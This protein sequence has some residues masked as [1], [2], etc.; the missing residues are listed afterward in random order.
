VNEPG[1]FPQAVRLEDIQLRDFLF[2]QDPS[3]HESIIYG[4]L[5]LPESACEKGIE[6]WV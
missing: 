2:L 5:R 3:R 4:E 1:K 6:W